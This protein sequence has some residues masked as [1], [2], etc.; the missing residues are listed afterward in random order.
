MRGCAWTLLLCWLTVAMGG[1]DPGTPSPQLSTQ[2]VRTEDL[3]G[4]W[5]LVRAG[6]EAPVALNIKSLRIDI[7]TDGTWSSEVEMQGPYAGMSMKGRGT[8][9][10]SEGVLT[11]TAGANSGKSNVRLE[12]GR[13]VIDPDLSVLKDGKTEVTG[14]YER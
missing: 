2:Q 13:L 5:R 11:Y 1:C 4:R 3:V 12:S 10:L 8:W 9:S 14:E 7:A 6:G